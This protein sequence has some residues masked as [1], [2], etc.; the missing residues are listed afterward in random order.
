MGRKVLY[1]RGLR[2]IDTT[3]VAA[4]GTGTHEGHGDGTRSDFRDGSPRP[5][6]A[7][8]TLGNRLITQ[9]AR[10]RPGGPEGMRDTHGSVDFPRSP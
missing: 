7:R 2:P 4:G 9:G 10:A 1:V 6:G 3:A 8:A 5:G